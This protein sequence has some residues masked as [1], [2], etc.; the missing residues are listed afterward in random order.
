MRAIAD[1]RLDATEAFC[2]GNVFLPRLPRLH[3]SL[4]RWRELRR[5]VRA[6]AR[7]KQSKAGVLDSPKRRLIRGFTLRWLFMDLGRLQ[8]VGHVPAALAAS[9]SAIL[10]PALG[11][12]EAAPETPCE[13]LR[14]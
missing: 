9:G 14:R 10:C 13:N 11:D 1:D 6:R 7:R 8:F 4:S 3:D 5:V 12:F 2:G